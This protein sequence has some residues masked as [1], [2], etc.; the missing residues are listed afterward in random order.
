MIVLLAFIAFA[1]AQALIEGK[2]A[3]EFNEQ[4]GYLIQGK[5]ENITTLSYNELELSV[6]GPNGFRRNA[7]MNAHGKFSFHLARPGTYK[8]EV[9]NNRFFFEPVAVKIESDAA[10]V[11]SPTKKQ[12]S[13]TIWRLRDSKPTKLVY[14][15]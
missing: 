6:T 14:P 1:A 13:A 3:A 9:V 12:I 7:F 10:L 15:L 5:V 11:E 4:T 2:P 8:L